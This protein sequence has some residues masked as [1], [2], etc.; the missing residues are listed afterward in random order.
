MRNSSNVF[1]AVDARLEAAIEP[2]LQHM[3][4]RANFAE[5][6]ERRVNQERYQETRVAQLEQLRGPLDQQ[7]MLDVG[8]GMGGFAVAAR[9]RGATV[10]AC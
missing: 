10:A 5:W 8:A 3:R 6:R 1:D 7:V 4:W 9:L 2:W